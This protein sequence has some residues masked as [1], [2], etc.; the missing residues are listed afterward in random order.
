MIEALGI[1]MVKNEADVIEAFVRHNLNFM[2]AM[3]IIDNDSVDDTR[4][5][6]VCLQRDGLPII[7]FDDPVVGHFQAEIVTAV[8]RKVVPQFKPRFV[9][10]LDADEFIV[11]PSR[12]T[13]YS[14]LRALRPGTQAQY[15]WRTYIPAPT[16]PEGD[17]SDPLRS[18]THRRAVEQPW[19]KPVIV[20]NPKID[21]KVSIKQ[22]NHGASYARLPLRK[23][24]LH[25]V[26]I[27]HFPVRSV[28]QFTSKILVGWIANLE[29][30]RYR[31]DMAHG[32]HWKVVYDRIVRGPAFTTEDLTLEALRYAQL[33]KSD[34]EWPR[35]VV[36]DPVAPGYTKLTA[37]PA[38]TTT[39]LQ[40]VV[41]S[42]D[43]I[44]NPEADLSSLDSDIRFLLASDRKKKSRPLL[45]PPSTNDRSGNFESC[46]DLPPF[47]YLA[48]R[49]CPDSVL[50]FGCESGVY[51]RYFASHGAGL[52]KGVDCGERKPKYLEADE[53]ARGDLG[54]PLN[55]GRTFDLVI[56]AGLANVDGKLD[57][58]RVANIT[59]HARERIVLFGQ[60]NAPAGV[61]G[62]F[63]A[64][65]DSFASA[66]WNPCL[67]DSL[68][69]R[70]LSTVP[71]FRQGTVVLTRDSGDATVTDRLIE[72]DERSMKWRKRWPAL[73]T[74]PFTETE[75]RLSVRRDS[76]AVAMANKVMRAIIARAFH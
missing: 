13:L 51:L 64:T 22:G 9:F 63:S 55:L 26:T 14:Q 62:A 66:G 5:I 1:A 36:R 71:W 58:T 35:D 20:T 29:R 42:I 21:T 49:Y 24:K 69:L 70:S 52:V 17:S 68:T 16:G 59:R 34:F 73:I 6:L 48:E 7:I 32:I 28:E 61:R 60:R 46:I 74:H 44:F 50:E 41:R 10:L 8:Y 72:L 43:R 23:V 53:F 75:A 11:T 57:Q 54:N 33:S 38:S 65:L 67:F 3:V 19:Y 40:K 27:A 47:R 45:R 31:L 76:R 30:N 15:A 2:D 25:D 39:S 18:I 37:R 12:E 4:E 56:C